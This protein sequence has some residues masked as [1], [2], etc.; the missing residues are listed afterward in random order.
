MIDLQDYRKFYGTRFR[1]NVLYLYQV[2]QYYGVLQY[3]I[4]YY[5]NTHRPRERLRLWFLSACQSVRML[6]VVLYSRVLPVVSALYCLTVS[7]S[8]EI[9]DHASCV[10]TKTAIQN[11]SSETA[12][13][14]VATI[15]ITI[16]ELPDKTNIG[17][18]YSMSH[19]ERVCQTYQG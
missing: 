11:S 5:S 13:S 15:I 9:C 17:Y 1:Y 3:I 12:A 2:L 6:P 14:S 16:V 19:N 4:A 8:P 10:V 7:K 18:L